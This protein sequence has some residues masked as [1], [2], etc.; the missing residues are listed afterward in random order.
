MRVAPVYIIT[1]IPRL[2]FAFPPKG[3]IQTSG[4]CS[5]KLFTVAR[6]EDG[7]PLVVRRGKTSEPNG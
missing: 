2:L 1:I 5:A 4:I 3:L 7:Y 6:G